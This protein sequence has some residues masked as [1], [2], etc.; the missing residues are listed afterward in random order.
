M[1]QSCIYLIKNVF[2]GILSIYP[3]VLYALVFMWFHMFPSAPTLSSVVFYVPT[4]LHNELAP[5][6]TNKVHETCGCLIFK[7]TSTVLRSR[8]RDG[9]SSSIH[10]G[11]LSSG[12]Q[13]TTTKQK[14]P[15]QRQKTMEHKKT[16]LTQSR[17]SRDVKPVFFFPSVPEKHWSVL[18][19]T[20]N[21]EHQS[22]TQSSGWPVGI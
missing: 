7:N 15:M 22:I 17:P 21:N 20:S 11:P 9:W 10:D 8:K 14:L 13:N 16:C 4:P 12:L 2:I 19:F 3:C 5:L 1:F 18:Y 6:G